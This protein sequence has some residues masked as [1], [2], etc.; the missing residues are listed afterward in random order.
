MNIDLTEIIIATI[1]LVM[2]IISTLITKYLIPF[3]KE[4]ISTEQFNR[5]KKWVEVAV[6]AAEQTI[7]DKGMGEAKKAEVLK[8]L[9]EKGFTVDF[10]ELD[11]LIEAA[12]FEINNGIEDE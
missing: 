8:F 4:K 9:N 5:M 3:I 11:K 6:K 2:G 10:E 1:T 12:V 7:T